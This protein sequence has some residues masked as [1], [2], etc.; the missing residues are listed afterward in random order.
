MNK[1][2]DNDFI[3]YI[4]DIVKIGIHEIDHAISLGLKY[5][6]DVDLELTE[7]QKKIMK[8]LKKNLNNVEDEIIK[9]VKR[10]LRENQDLGRKKWKNCRTCKYSSKEIEIKPC[11][12][13]FKEAV[14]PC[15]E[16]IE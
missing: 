15:W 16:P 6:D 1:T 5:D 11:L 2:K 8:E 4:K 14:Y 12:K 10:E 13:C 3:D 9:R 7:K